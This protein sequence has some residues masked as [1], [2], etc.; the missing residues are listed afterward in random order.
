M[1]VLILL[2]VYLVGVAVADS[3][4]DAENVM[5]VNMKYHTAV[6]FDVKSVYF[7]FYILFRR[8]SNVRNS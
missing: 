3:D 4:S 2:V 8:L 1:K 5:M 6:T 7:L